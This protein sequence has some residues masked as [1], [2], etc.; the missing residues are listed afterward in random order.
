M[1]T[2]IHFRINGGTRLKI[3][4]CLLRGNVFPFIAF[5][6]PLVHRKPSRHAMLQSTKSVDVLLGSFCIFLLV[7]LLA[8]SCDDA[9]AEELNYARPS[10]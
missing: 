2:G 8:Q 5:N 10:L 7:H 4:R 3:T 6:F 9:R 1:L